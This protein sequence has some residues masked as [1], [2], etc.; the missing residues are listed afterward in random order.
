MWHLMT[1]P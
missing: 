1:K